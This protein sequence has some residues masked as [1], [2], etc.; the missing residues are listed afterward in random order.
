MSFLTLC[1]L[2]DALEKENERNKKIGASVRN[3]R[4][5][6]WRSNQGTEEENKCTMLIPDPV[7]NKF[8]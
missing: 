5:I 8:S 3:L 1:L 4:T 7:G 6:N 2:T